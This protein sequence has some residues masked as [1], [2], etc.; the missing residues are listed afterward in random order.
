M[1]THIK[2][3]F[4]RPILGAT[5]DRYHLAPEDVHLLDGF[6]NFVYEFQRDES[7]Y[8]LRIAHSSRRT[9][10]QIQGEVDWIN[11]L[12][13]GGAAVARAVPS[14]GGRLV[15][16]IDDGHGEQF[17]ATAFV[18]APGAKPWTVDKPADYFERYGRLLGR[19]HALTQKY[20]PSNPAWTRPQWDDPLLLDVAGFLPASETIAL[21]KHHAV[22]EHLRT[23]PRDRGSFGL[24]H[25]DAHEANLFL[26]ADGTL[27]LFDFDD[28]CYHWFADDI[29]IVLFYAATNYEDAAAFAAE[30]LPRFLAGYR[31]ANLLDPRWLAEIPAFLK[32]REIDLYAVIHR[33]FDVENLDDPWCARYMR[34]R[35][36]R[37]ESDVPTIEFDFDSLAGAPAPGLGEG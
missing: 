27:T 7:G 14:A 29:A 11:Y 18:K 10:N 36:E 26:A 3:K 15:E 17:L 19:M 9:A 1:E 13:R 37:I 16:A 25:H 2:A 33:S 5:L 20:Q 8:I 12:A 31:Q 4:T 23:L 28:C 30:F 32:L 22:V 34:G 6:E 24:I 35:R 21:E